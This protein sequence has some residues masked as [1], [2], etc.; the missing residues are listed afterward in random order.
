MEN[1]NKLDEALLFFLNESLERIILS[2][3]RTK[4][5]FL[6]LV[7]R[8]L[9]LQGE[10]KLQ[11]EEFTEKQAFH[12][13]MGAEEAAGYVKEQLLTLYRNG[14]IQSKLG[15]GTV[16]VSKKGTVTVKIKKNGKERGSR[17]EESGEN[18]RRRTEP[19]GHQPPVPPQPEKELCAPGG[20]TG[21]LPRGSG[22]DDKGGSGGKSQIR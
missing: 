7:L 11:A 13:N 6:K 14:E 20:N 4:D 15:S 22:S 5:G 17:P 18:L 12:K 9:L 8:P 3:P 10:L 19:G 2:N 1:E 16:L 21:S